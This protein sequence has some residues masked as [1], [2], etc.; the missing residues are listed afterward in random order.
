MG[1]AP[2]AAPDEAQHFIRAVGVSQGH[3]IGSAD[4]SARIG[5]TPTQ[6]AW[7]TQAARIVSLPQGLD[8]GAFACELGPSERS[9]ACLNAANPHPSAVALVTTVGNYQPIPYLL[10]AVALRAA[11][12]ASAALR[13]A[14]AAGALVALALLA[15][16]VFA[17]YDPERP[18]LSLL[19]LILAVTPMVV[20]CAASL[21]GSGTEI[22]G[23]IAFFSCLLR[24]GRTDTPCARWWAC[25]AISG[26]VLALSRSASPAWLLLALLVG[27][28]WEGPRTFVRRWTA[29]WVQRATAGVL[30]FAVALNRVWEALYGSHASLDTAKLHAGLVA[31]VHQWWRAFPELVGK[32]GYLEVK[33]PVVISLLWFMLVAAIIV[34]AC[35]VCSRR[36]RVVIV[37]V[38]LAGLLGPV[39]FYALLIRPTGFG[40]QGRHVLPFLAVVPLLAGEAVTAHS[41]LV[42]VTWLRILVTTIPITAGAMQL[43][44]WYLNAK[45]Y[46]VGGF[47][48]EWFMGRAAWSPPAGWWPW[49]AASL[50]ASVC[51]CAVVRVGRGTDRSVMAA[52]PGL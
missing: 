28:G 23:A 26:A 8:P 12:S 34:M 22:T 30:V 15:V 43:V 2:F 35:I 44:A 45:R 14:R 41:G 11:S 47:G 42:K 20:F 37:L 19:G 49:L 17:L 39:A 9:A 1:N 6:V 50:L 36:E 21:S 27:A 51:F 48:P 4:P 16:A 32:F 40:L 52:R 18:S 38:L 3:L 7:T 13:L 46:A 24:L 5:S 25:A 10:P 29:G 31:G 33:L